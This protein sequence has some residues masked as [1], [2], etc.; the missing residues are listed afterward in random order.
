M[1]NCAVAG[2]VADNVT[3]AGT[4]TIAGLLLVSVTIARDG[5][6]TVPV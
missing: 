4:L 2:N 1:V 6:D 3:L 5:P